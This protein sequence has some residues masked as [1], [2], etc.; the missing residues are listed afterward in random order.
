MTGASDW[1]GRVGDTW[2]AEWQRT[3]RAFDGIAERLDQAILAL[4]PDAG[5]A[6]DIGCGAGATTVSL[7]TARPGLHVTGV[8]L[9][10]ALLTVAQSR[11]TSVD[12]VRFEMGD[13]VA[14]AARL[15]PLDLLVS[16]HGVMFFADPVVG[17]AGL[18]SACRP[19]APLIFSCFRSRAENDWAQA[20]D[21]AIGHTAAATGYA[22]G[23]FALADQA[24]TA[25]ILGRAGW[26]DIAA[27]PYDVS[28]IVGAGDDPVGD[29]LAYYRRIGSAAAILAA[30]SPGERSRMERG[31]TDLLRE[32]MAPRIQDPRIQ[33]PRI[34]GDVVT[35]TAAIWI[36]TAR[37]GERPS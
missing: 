13:A 10:S 12:Q 32:R 6:L 16:R 29:A 28:Y 36:W 5:S 23:P 22:P 2:A 8:D 11:A 7:A 9:S 17:F 14:V 15:A 31:L 25:A 33:D 26:Q 27:T 1:R 18:A 24:A 4:A 19:G 37:A 20:V 35:F 3:E 34:Q 21:R 30:A